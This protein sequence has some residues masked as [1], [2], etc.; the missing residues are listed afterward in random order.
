MGFRPAVTE[1]ARNFRIRIMELG[2]GWAA[3]MVVDIHD[4]PTGEFL[5][6]DIE[7]TGVGRYATAAEAVREAE[8]WTAAEGLPFVG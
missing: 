5:Y 3:V 6:H 2:S 1:E 4:G 7:Q 8:T